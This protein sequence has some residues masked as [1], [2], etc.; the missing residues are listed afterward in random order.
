MHQSGLIS[1]STDMQQLVSCVLIHLSIHSD[2][3]RVPNGFQYMN[4]KESWK[5]ALDQL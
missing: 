5:F 3:T 1:E 4:Q 2:V